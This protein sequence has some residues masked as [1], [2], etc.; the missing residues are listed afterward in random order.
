VTAVL[1]QVTQHLEFPTEEMPTNGL[2]AEAR[3]K[4]NPLSTLLCTFFGKEGETA[5][6]SLESLI[7]EPAVGVGTLREGTL[8]VTPAP[9][10]QYTFDILLALGTLSFFLNRVT[11]LPIQGFLGGQL[12][13]TEA[14]KW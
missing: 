1:S 9:A 7:P 14:S 10:A 8:R 11:C 6:D 4:R 5:S 2:L 12:L 13:L 3:D